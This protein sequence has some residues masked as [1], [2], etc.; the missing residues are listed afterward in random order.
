[1]YRLTR[2]VLGDAAGGGAVG[3]VGGIA[4]VAM[5]SLLSVE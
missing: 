5:Q 3:V 4:A 2:G 1:M